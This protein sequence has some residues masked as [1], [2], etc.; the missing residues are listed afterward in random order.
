MFF[1]MQDMCYIS[2]VS[3]S[4]TVHILEIFQI[5]KMFDLSRIQ[6]STTLKAF[7]A[8]AIFNALVRV[9]LTTFEVKT[10]SLLVI[11]AKCSISSSGKNKHLPKA[12]SPMFQHL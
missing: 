12:S 4:S 10:P 7:I 5:K 6:A 11:N 3:C 9:I 1:F 8:N 2:K